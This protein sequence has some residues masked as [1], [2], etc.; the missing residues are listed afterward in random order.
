MDHSLD[1]QS[2]SAVDLDAVSVR[3]IP[4]EFKDDIFH[5]H[6]APKAERVEK[7][8][9]SG[10]AEAQGEPGQMADSRN[11]TQSSHASASGSVG[12]ATLST[13]QIGKFPAHQF[14]QQP[15]E[16]SSGSDTS[17][18]EA[19]TL[20]KT[21]AEMQQP[22]GDRCSLTKEKTDKEMIR[23]EVDSS[24]GN[25]PQILHPRPRN[26]RPLVAVRMWEHLASIINQL[27]PPGF[28]ALSAIS[29]YGLGLGAK[30]AQPEAD[31]DIE[32]G[33][34]VEEISERRVLRPVPVIEQE[35]TFPRLYDPADMRTVLISTRGFEESN[36][37]A[38]HVRLSGLKAVA[39]KWTLLSLT[40]E[41]T[42]KDGS[43]NDKGDFALVRLV[44]R[45]KAMEIITLIHGEKWISCGMGIPR[46]LCVLF[47]EPRRGGEVLIEGL[48]MPEG[49]SGK[50]MRKLTLFLLLYDL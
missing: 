39:E 44:P 9:F 11:R 10:Q 45:K 34:S 35:I 27:P 33:G 13:K 41:E 28:A 43:A 16:N 1:D 26:R 7:G 21:Q 49:D 14:R 29:H 36:M 22:R 8:I 24:T 48:T 20:K 42:S 32:A 50:L 12:K 46:R 6:E 19:E 3:S 18:W 25:Q 37:L 4:G 2:A 40:D 17:K 5:G 15:Y 47:I 31:D 23:S 38:S 30:T